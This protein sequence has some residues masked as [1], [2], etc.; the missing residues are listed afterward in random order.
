LTKNISDLANKII[1][2][3]PTEAASIW[4]SIAEDR[5]LAIEVHAAL[6]QEGRVNLAHK[7]AQIS[8]NT[9]NTHF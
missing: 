2:S 8:E 3:N 1:L 5:A 9:Q 6:G 7:L 4:T